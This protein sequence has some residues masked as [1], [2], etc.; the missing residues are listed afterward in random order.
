MADRENFWGGWRERL[1]AL[2]NVPPVLRIVWQSGPLVVSLGLVFRLISSLIPL[3]ALWITKLIIDGIVLAVSSHQP[4]KPLLWWLVAAEFAIA[5]FGSILGRTIDYV[6]ALLADKYTRHISIR[7]MKHAA[8]LDLIA[9]EDPVFYDRLERA[10]V[11][12]TDRL[13]MIQSIGRL[14]QQVITAASLSVSILLFSPWL[15]LLPL[16]IA[17][18]LVSVWVSVVVLVSPVNPPTAMISSAVKSARPPWCTRTRFL[19]L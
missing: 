11:Q 1:A 16:F 9:Y 2:R 3:A 10:R 12:A 8:D 17:L 15:L 18:G 5:I 19:D 7:V 6:D 4:V 13:G 14:V